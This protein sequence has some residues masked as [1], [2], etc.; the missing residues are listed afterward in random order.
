MSSLRLICAAS[1][2]DKGLTTNGCSHVGLTLDNRI[3]SADSLSWYIVYSGLLCGSNASFDMT[4]TPA[5]PHSSRMP[6]PTRMD[7]SSYRSS[8]CCVWDQDIAGS[9]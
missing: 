6:L 7:I 2:G 9:T 3:G 8:V 5:S 4:K 1:T